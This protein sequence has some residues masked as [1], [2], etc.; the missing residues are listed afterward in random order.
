MI[1]MLIEIRHDRRIYVDIDEG[2]K[3]DD[4][5][6]SSLVVLLIH[7]SCAH[8]GQ[9]DAQ[10]NWLRKQAQQKPSPRRIVRYD[11]FGCGKSM[12]P[13]DNASTI[14]SASEHYADLLAIYERYCT[15]NCKVW[16]FGHS[17]GCSMALR[18]AAE[19]NEEICKLVL[20][21]PPSLDFGNTLPWIFSLPV[22][23][24][25]WI[26]PLLTDGFITR[27]F[28]PNTAEKQPELIDSERSVSNANP[29]YMFKAFY[30]SMVNYYNTEA[31][32]EAR[33]TWFET[34][35]NRVFIIRGENDQIAPIDGSKQLVQQLESSQLS[36]VG[37]AS[38][39]VMQEQPDMVNELLAT[40]LFDQTKLK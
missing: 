32:E 26:Q 30:Q 7:G 3:D 4:S 9:W 36:E 5:S 10:V 15:S 39:Q 18:L 17:F 16:V 31:N 27:A 25:K 24:L 2:D 8:S 29:P 23:V 21:S 33:S 35:K 40:Y 11:Y 38:H 12:K 13:S 20:M 37:S 1:K 6:E 34:V 28:H 14:Y 19:K 22:W